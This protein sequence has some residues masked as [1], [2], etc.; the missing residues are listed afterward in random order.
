METFDRAANTWFRNMLTFVKVSIA[1]AH[2][3]Q[4]LI[5][6]GAWSMFIVLM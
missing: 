1:N 5:K 2:I 4:A 6:K 3:A